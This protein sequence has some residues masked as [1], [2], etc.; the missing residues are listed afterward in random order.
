MNFSDVFCQLG[1]GPFDPIENI[2]SCNSYWDLATFRIA[3]L[4]LRH[5]NHKVLP[6]DQWPPALLQTTDD[7]AYGGYPEAGDRY[8]KETDPKQ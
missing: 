5:F 1:S 3:T 8:R 7:V 6:H 4:M 2:I